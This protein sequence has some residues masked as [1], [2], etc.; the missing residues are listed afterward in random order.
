M[1]GVESGDGVEVALRAY[2]AE[3]APRAASLVK[4]SRGAGRVCLLA[5]PLGARLRNFAMG[6]MP[7]GLRMR[8]FDRVVTTRAS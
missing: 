7:S 6:V 8:Q 5:S 2:E 4:G 1:H 3:R